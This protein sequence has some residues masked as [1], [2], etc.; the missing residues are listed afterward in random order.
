[1]GAS[2]GGNDRNYTRL[3]FTDTVKAVQAR[4]G[5]REAY[6]KVERSGDRFALG[7]RERQFIEARDSFYM[8]SVGSNGWPYVQYR[9]GPKGFL[10]VIDPATLAFADFRGNRQYISTGNVL[11]SGRV[12]LILMDYPNRDRLK[13]WAQASITRAEEDPALG[14]RVALDGYNAIVE[15]IFV[16]KVA[17]FDWNCTQ[18][19]I[20]RYTLDE[21]PAPV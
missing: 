10:R 2:S 9:G 13:I 16:L 12:A 4:H 17:A 7:R 14:S 6:A 15:R 1:M 18:H 8:A 3:A 21:L 19:I 5:S 20:P 11:D